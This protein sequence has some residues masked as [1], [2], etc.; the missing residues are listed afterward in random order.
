MVHALLR[1]PLSIWPLLVSW[2]TGFGMTLI[3]SIRT[4]SVNRMP[5]QHSRSPGR[6][7]R[8]SSRIAVVGSEP[9]TSGMPGCAL[10]GGG[11]RSGAL[12][13]FPATKVDDDEPF[14]ERERPRFAP[15]DIVSAGSEM[16]TS[17]EGANGI[18]ELCAFGA[19]LAGANASSA[20]VAETGLSKDNFR[21]EPPHLMYSV[22]PCIHWTSPRTS[23]QSCPRS[24]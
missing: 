10:S 5:L 18:A 21:I 7:S 23:R 11:F 24:E 4:S 1:D 16:L 6:T 20:G 17:E 15:D 13:T 12:T 8:V 9:C 2:L 14:G 19:A 3:A 22:L